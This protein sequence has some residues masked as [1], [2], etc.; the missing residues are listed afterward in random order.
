[1]AMALYKHW[2]V[3][4]GPFRDGEFVDSEMGRIPTGWEVGKISGIAN[5]TSGKRPPRKLDI[6]DYQIFGGGGPMGFADSFLFNQNIII[7]GRVGTLG[8]VFRIFY[9]VW[10]SDNTLVLFPKVDI[11]YELLFHLVQQIDF[12]SLNRGSTQPLV[13]QTD[14]ANQRIIIPKREWIEKFHNA[15]SRLFLHADC[16][17][18]ESQTLARTRDYLLPRLLSGEIKVKAA[19]E[20][21]SELV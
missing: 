21:I 2:F 20:Q 13:T 15:I 3:D 19:A 17:G 11:Y 14:I 10:P 6:G 12:E 8:K 4:F 16:N 9:P 1:M 18:K 7:T 5:V